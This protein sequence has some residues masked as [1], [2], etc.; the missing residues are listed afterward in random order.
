MNAPVAR[1]GAIAVVIAHYTLDLAK[2]TCY[3][4][5]TAGPS[6]TTQFSTQPFRATMQTSRTKTRL[7]PTLKQR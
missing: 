2:K 7:H 6:A 5:R 4:G 1:A 3:H